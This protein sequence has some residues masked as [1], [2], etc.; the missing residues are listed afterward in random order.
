M[1]KAYDAPGRYVG[2]MQRVSE[3]LWDAWRVWAAA[4]KDERPGQQAINSY[5]AAIELAEK[6]TCDAQQVQSDYVE[7]WRAL[8]H[9]MRPSGE[10]RHL[11]DAVDTLSEFTESLLEAQRTLTRTTFGILRAMDNSGAWRKITKRTDPQ[12]AFELWEEF[13]DAW[14]RA[15]AWPAAGKTSWRMA[16]GRGERAATQRNRVNGDRSGAAG[17]ASSGSRRGRK[18]VSH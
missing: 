11:S 12:T 3:S 5:A 17:Q 15:F 6:L 14:S 9:P 2:A 7:F 16:G 8:A 18:A 10:V 4:D 13:F 1:D